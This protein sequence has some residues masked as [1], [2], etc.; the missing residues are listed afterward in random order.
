[1]KVSWYVI[2]YTSGN[3][4]KFKH[5]V[6]EIQE[7]LEEI[8]KGN[9]EGIHEEYQ[10]VLHFFQLWLFW[11][12]NIDGNIWKITKDSVNKFMARRKV[13]EKI[14]DYV[15]LNKDISRFCGNYKR[16]YKVIKHLSAFGI[17]EAKAKLAFEKIVEGE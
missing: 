17:S 15:G 14:Y 8:K 2:N 3:R 10:D 11:Q 6:Q 5:I 1:M 16:E 7:L 9:R 4:I 13:W 12:F